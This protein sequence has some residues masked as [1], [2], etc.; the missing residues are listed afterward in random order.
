LFA[1]ITAEVTQPALTSALECNACPP[2]SHSRENRNL[3]LA[4]NAGRW[5]RR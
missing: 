2:S 4:G 1:K 5:H 3:R